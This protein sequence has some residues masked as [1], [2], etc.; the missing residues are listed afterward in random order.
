[1]VPALTFVGTINAVNYTGAHPHFIDSEKDFMNID[2]EK[3]ENYLKKIT[4][5]K[6]NL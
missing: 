2:I 4:K 6:T 1:M 5:L 3:L